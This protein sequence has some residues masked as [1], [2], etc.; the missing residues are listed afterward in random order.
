ME[1]ISPFEN[2]AEVEQ[3]P[4]LYEGAAEQIEDNSIPTPAI[5]ST[6]LLAALSQIDTSKDPELQLAQ[7]AIEQSRELL[8][9]GREQELRLKVAGKRQQRILSGL[10]K[11]RT[12]LGPMASQKDVG[13]VDEAYSR[14]LNEDYSQRARIAL[15][16]EAVERIQDMAA[17]NPVQARVLLDNLERGDANKTIADYW[18]RMAVLQQRAE[19]LDQE[20]NQSG[21]GM[22]AINFV[23]NL[24][25]LNYNAA[26]SG[27]VKDAD[28]GFFDFFM[29]GTNQA[30]QA[31]ALQNM[32]MDEFLEYTKKDGEFM[33]SL[34]SNA[35]TIFDL[36]SDPAAAVE[37]MNNLISLDD[38]DKS[39][40]NI[41]GG[42]EAA[43]VVPWGRVAGVTKSIVRA[44]A[45][46]V[47]IN[48]LDNALRILDE[49]GPEAM[50]R[51]TGVT[52]REVVDEL[53]ISAINPSRTAHEVPL[54]EQIATR[55][56]AARR[57]LDEVLDPPSGE[58]FRTVE[59]IKAAYDSAVQHFTKEYGRPI[60]DVAFKTEKLAGGGQV[61]YVEVTFGKK[62]GS[63]FAKEM[64][65]L[66]AARPL[67]GETVEV[68]ETVARV[69]DPKEGFNLRV[70][71]GT[72]K[73]FD[74]AIRPSTEG[75]L[76]PG[77]YATLDPKT[78]ELF[79]T[80]YNRSK[81]GAN[82][83]PLLV[84][85]EKIFGLDRLKGWTNEEAV[86]TLKMLGID[87][88]I[89]STVINKTIREGDLLNS[90]SFLYTTG[91]QLFKRQLARGEGFQSSSVLLQ[92]RI[93]AI[94]YE[95]MAARTGNADELVVF[96]ADN[97]K[98][99]FEPVQT[100][101]D[102]SGQWYARARINVPEQGF[103]TNALHTETQG[104]L[105][106][107]LGRYT[108][109]APRISDPELHGRAVTAGS[110]V[111]RAQQI[112][113]RNIMKPFRE[114]NKQSREVV[115]Q[116]AL[117]GANDERWFSE[118]EFKFLVQ[119]GFG[120]EATEAELKAYNNLILVNDMDWV[121]R[122]DM[123][124]MDG[125]I[126]GK[127]SVE[128][129]TPWGQYIDEDVRINYAPDKV[130]TERVWNMSDNVHY[131]RQSN[132]LSSKELDR[133]RDRGYVMLEFPEGFR[134]PNGVVVNRVLT[135]KTDLIIKPL[136]RNQLAYTE[137]GHRIY[138]DRYFVKQGR[139]GR[140]SDTG[141][142]YLEAPGTF[143]TAAN[144]AEAS[145]WARVMD[146]ARYLVKEEEASAQRLDDE[147][148]AGSNA[149]PSGDEFLRSVE[150]GVV[151]LDHPF[152]AVYNRE[153]PSMY[154]K[155]GEDISKFFNEDE[156]G[157]NGYYRTT[158]KM[159]TS[160]KGEHLKDVSGSLA[161]T[162]DPYEALTTSLRQITRAQGLFHYKTEALE[163]F[164]NTF[165][166][167][168]DTRP[169]DSLSRIVTEGKVRG[170]V[171]AEIRNKIEA[172]REAI[173][174]VLRFETPHDKIRNELY[175]S[176]AEWVLGTGDNA[177]RRFAHDAVYWWQEKN[178]VAFIRGLA[179]DSKLG[180]FNIGQLFIQSS[181]MISATALSPK[182]GMRGMMGLYPM[183]SYLLSRGSEAVLDNL[184]KRGTWKT[185]GFD[186]V[187]EF[188][189]YARHAN[190]SGFMD[191]NGSHIMVNEYGPT[192]HFGSF[193]EKAAAARDTGR[194]FFYTAE[195]WN[196]LV[197]Y[198]IAWGEAKDL[199]LKAGDPTFNSTIL[200]LADDYSMN[201]T[202]E[203]AS[204]WQKGLLSIPTQF[205]AYNVR[206][207]D[208]MFGKRFTPAQRIRLALANVGMAGAAGIPGV[209]ALSTYLK[210]QN[211]E[212]PDI[213][214]LYGV[215]D[216]GLLD[217]FAYQTTG[218]DVL[219]GEKVGTG[220]W[221][222]DTVKS[223]FGA[224]EYGERSFMDIIGGATYSIG[225]SATT[226]GF[227]TLKHVTM[228]AAA[229]SGSDMGEF[230]IAQDSFLKM[231]K[232][233]STFGNATKA[234]LVAQ[235]GI[236]KSKQGT[237]LADELPDSDAVFVALGFRPEKTDEIGYRMKWLENNEESAKEVAKQL[238]NW[239]QEAMH[240]P[241]KFE[242]N[243]QKANVLMRL[244]PPSQR[245]D[246]L[247]QTNK[248]TED[249]FYDF[250]SRK[251]EE[252][253]LE[254][255]TTE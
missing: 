75:K 237:I 4:S 167:F 40:A 140:Q 148:F 98:S 54:S 34:R 127:E 202:R 56:E 135:K 189:A 78:A 22:A 147:V 8:E 160:S 215:M 92:E 108:R 49:A 105:S 15:E 100:F 173:L 51:A 16:E 243:M 85:P 28:T 241:E 187:D 65:A 59:E 48:N 164:K 179:F 1:T 104:F 162:V 18:S 198:R 116:I 72:D 64:T 76:G 234:M 35:T 222:S 175:R 70:Y 50:A 7:G 174:H 205:W 82:I 213:D 124:Y 236:Y 53:S 128:F 32:P 165:G 230:S 3:E 225:K 197:A 103:Y 227:D 130:P 97:I 52:E 86:S 158:G 73:E 201:M 253:K 196:R 67:G 121:L 156:L 77:V 249:S 21:W 23:L 220:G 137:G 232:E 141:T 180:M 114:L 117:K 161:P 120:R 14:V 188:K 93:K 251:V 24:I 66:N 87:D 242:E 132:P 12:G 102:V 30:K 57:A 233:I 142:E 115:E 204:W 33:K 46:S 125:V 248:A 184:A 157:I 254:L 231:L 91:E 110:I 84:R 83:H 176:T 74:G 131:T 194:V 154:Q 255:G 212:A 31:A 151:N 26:R 39:W 94:G 169:N 106:R 221:A 60:K 136:R 238:R 43:L 138:T 207:M 139:M 224:S 217:Y 240:V 239:R 61:R 245:R 62:D 71:H 20:Y 218:A 96:E 10:N 247:R 153:L 152:E 99:V 208:A 63:G 192:A 29:S 2:V 44:G 229:E 168:L 68:V 235:Y 90:G 155:S 149:F 186:S 89:I 126:K 199:G 228:Y 45:P 177:A 210:Q 166:Q 170:D 178:P 146:R 211:G 133:L 113:E 9:M 144:K 47:A 244:L 163:R 17:S 95:G 112:I 200:R 172:Q 36:T 214:S 13:A 190:G 107:L 55:Q 5:T 119:R 37:I 109:A 252:E 80:L 42:A 25:P 203:S 118:V 111:N 223:L 6:A 79:G 209:A 183:H 159:Y 181:T 38:N 123:M 88:E 206:M 185:M 58:R 216:R 129:E 134:L 122:N 27:I 150:D 145:K 226:A 246:V 219:I 69:V 193:A 81:N 101:R 250:V 11:L 182:Y 195:T 171:P 191:M 19:E 143:V 41:W